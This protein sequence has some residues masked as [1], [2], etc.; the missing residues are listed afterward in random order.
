MVRTA[1]AL[2]LLVCG[3]AVRFLGFSESTTTVGTHTSLLSVSSY[4]DDETYSAWEDYLAQGQH[5]SPSMAA[6]GSLLGA[7]ITSS[8][9]SNGGNSNLLYFNQTSA[10]AMLDPMEADLF[11]FQ[12]GW[13][14]QITQALCA[15][16]TTAALLNSLRDVGPQFELPMDPIYKPYPFATQNNILSSA[17]TNSCVVEALG[18]TIYNRDA[19]YHMGLG[20][21]MVPK[22]ANCFLAS[23]GYE[24]IGHPAVSSEE[25]SIKAIVLQALKDPSQRVVYNYDRGGIGQGPMGHGHWSPLGGYNEATDSFLVMDVA[26]YKHPMVWVTWED[27]WSGANTID[28]CGETLALGFIDWV[29]TPF[30]ELKKYLSTRCI[31]GNRGFV[32]VRSINGEL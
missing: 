24:A 29:G 32:V 31:P 1:M 22:L 26:K 8:L 23:N 19:V 3:L 5:H 17:E 25:E 20:L 14:A 2:G 15:I 11:H 30:A 21:A 6:A 27:L 10:F 16:A 18:G 7:E 28:T 12:N 4:W 9:E 13:E